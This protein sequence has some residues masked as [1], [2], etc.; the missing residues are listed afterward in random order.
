LLEKKQKES[1]AKSISDCIEE[2]INSNYGDNVAQVI[3]NNLS[4]RFGLNK[5]D[6]ADHPSK[7]EEVLDNIFGDGPACLLI[8]STLIKEL[9]RH[10]PVEVEQEKQGSSVSHTIDQIMSNAY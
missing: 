2:A 7:F 1:L 6:I 5:T 10:F 3:F 4:V 9:H 8:K